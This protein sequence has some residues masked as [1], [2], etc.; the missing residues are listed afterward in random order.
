M[1]DISWIIREPKYRGSDIS[2]KRSSYV[3]YAD[4]LSQERTDIIY[5]VLDY[6]IHSSYQSFYCISQYADFVLIEDVWFNCVLGHLVS[7]TFFQYFRFLLPLHKRIVL[8]ANSVTRKES[9]RI[10]I[11]LHISYAM[12]ASL[13]VSLWQ[14]NDHGSIYTQCH[15]NCQSMYHVISKT[16]I[17]NQLKVYSICV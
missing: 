16:Q 13:A 7:I 3:T 8:V 4:V 17:I 14:S 5:K 2:Y 6:I 11:A 10:F 9:I 1:E 12:C 15:V